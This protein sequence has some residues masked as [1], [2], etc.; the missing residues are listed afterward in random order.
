V[1]DWARP[2]VLRDADRVNQQSMVVQYK[3]IVSGYLLA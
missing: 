1:G 2:D 3:P